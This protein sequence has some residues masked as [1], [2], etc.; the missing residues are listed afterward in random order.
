MGDSLIKITY[1]AFQSS[2]RSNPF[3]VANGAVQLVIYTI[4]ILMKF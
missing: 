1:K 3:S 2:G 4:T